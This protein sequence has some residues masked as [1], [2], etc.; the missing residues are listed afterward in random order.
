MKRLLFV[1]ILLAAAWTLGAQ[2]GVP[3]VVGKDVLRMP[4]DA[5]NICIVDGRLYCHSA[6]VMLESATRNNRLVDFDASLE[7]MKIDDRI[8]FMMRH[9][10]SGDLYYTVTN[11]KGESLLYVYDTTGKKPV[12]RQVRLGKF[13]VVHPAFSSDGSILVF[14]SPDG[15]GFG[16]LDLWYSRLID[17]EWSEPRNFGH[18]VN[19]PYDESAP[20]MYGDY[21]IFASNG[22]TSYSDSSAGPRKLYVAKL[23]AS[24][25][26]G[27]TVMRIPIGCAPVQMLPYPYNSAGESLEMAVDLNSAK[28]YWMEQTQQGL[29]LC[30]LKGSLSGALAEG[31]VQDK[32]RKPVH[33]ARV[34]AYDSK[35]SYL[36][37]NATTDENGYYSIMLNSD[38]DYVVLTEKEGYF[39]SKVSL[40]TTRG[41]QSPDIMIT[42]HHADFELERLD[43]DRPYS[44]GSLFGPQADVE[45]S[46]S[47][48]QA[49]MRL[50]SY[51]VANP[52]IKS[53]WTV[54]SRFPNGEFSQMVTNQRI[55]TLREFVEKRGVAPARL[56]FVNGDAHQPKT[57]GSEEESLCEVVI[58]K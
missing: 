54:W 27:D 16:G 49:V 18:K 53:R 37:G 2:E 26:L 13:Q 44:L 15:L 6:N 35:G 40:S 42:E 22:R 10:V 39:E 55:A 30:E 50:V 56:I 7:M 52:T 3:A 28:G 4:A 36:V 12:S 1:A 58:S 45:L 41:N 32:D 21:L 14:S 43:L 33:G 8:D 31:F 17:G 46:E 47:G 57:G 9:P 48:E 29:I 20:C 11:K 19:T 25:Q 34:S 23:V 24:R 5:R 38:A 51:M